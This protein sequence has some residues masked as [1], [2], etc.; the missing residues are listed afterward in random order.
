MYEMYN[1]NCLAILPSKYQ[2][3]RLNKTKE[4]A[5]N[6]LYFKVDQ[7]ATQPFADPPIITQKSSVQARP[8]LHSPPEVGGGDK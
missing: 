4:S 6:A 1:K 7:M 5:G 3:I 2:E 8:L